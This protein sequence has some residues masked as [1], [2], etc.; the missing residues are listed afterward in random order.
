MTSPMARPPVPP[1]SWPTNRNSPP[2]PASSVKVLS[3]FLMP[4]RT[5]AGGGA[6]LPVTEG[7]VVVPAVYVDA[8][9]AFT[10][11]HVDVADVVLE[12]QA[13]VEAVGP[14]LVVE[15]LEQADD[16]LDQRVLAARGE[17]GLPV[18]PGELQVVLA[19]GRV[20]QDPVH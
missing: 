20:G 17:E 8:G 15:A 2:S 12:G 18:P 13:Q 3:V 7:S 6:F 14:Q 10:V 19:A 5:S 16:L 11:E 9:H 1:R 4:R